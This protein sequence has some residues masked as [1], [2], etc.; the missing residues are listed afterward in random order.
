MIESSMIETSGRISSVEEMPDPSAAAVDEAGNRYFIDAAYRI[1]RVDPAGA[2][3]II[4]TPEPIT[5]PAFVM[6]GPGGVLYV[7]DAGQDVVWELT[8]TAPAP[9]PVKNIEILNSASLAPGPLAPGSLATIRGGVFSQVSFGE[10]R[11]T[12]LASDGNESIVQVPS[13]LAPGTYEAAIDAARVPVT[14]AAAAPALF[15][16]IH[17]DGSR[18]TA[19]NPAERGSLVLLF[20][21]GQGVADAPIA[22]YFG[23][24][25]A[26]VLYSGP[27][28]GYPGLWQLNVRVPAGFVAPGERPATVSVGGAV[29]PSLPAYLK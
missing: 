21:T 18:N 25:E 14:I 23:G 26:E 28:P 5:L 9:D 6:V 29:A 3:I 19:G 7:A 15:G 20:G 13:S 10:T 8:P 17:T 27:A 1:A 12:I 4:E 2:V 11:A 16:V 22:V 24:Y